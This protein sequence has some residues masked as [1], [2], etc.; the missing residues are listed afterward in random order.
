MQQLFPNATQYKNTSSTFIPLS[1]PIKLGEYKVEKKMVTTFTSRSERSF[2]DLKAH[3]DANLQKFTRQAIAEM[4][5]NFPDYSC[6]VVLGQ[7]EIPY[8]AD[9]HSTLN[10]F[11]FNVNR[12]DITRK[13]FI[14]A[15]VQHESKNI[16]AQKKLDLIPL[17]EHIASTSIPDE[18]EA[19]EAEFTRVPLRRRAV[20]PEEPEELK[21]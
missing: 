9:E 19:F 15:Q 1:K 14:S 18:E 21:I 17:K 10:T 3:R 7:V 11:R 2:I 13:I 4:A 12:N 8:H 5:E 6:F 20:K 16:L